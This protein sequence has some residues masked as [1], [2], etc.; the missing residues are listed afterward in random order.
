MVPVSG[1]G[2][3]LPLETAGYL[4]GLIVSPPLCTEAQPTA[5][6]ASVGAGLFWGS[7]HSASSTM[8]LLP[9]QVGNAPAIVCIFLSPS[10]TVWDSDVTPLPSST[11]PHQTPTPGC[12]FSG[13]RGPRS[14]YLVLSVISLVNSPVSLLDWLESAMA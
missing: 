14:T 6:V 12:F 5:H 10:P 11:S 13:I 2:H 8:H 4:A 9:A 7:C 1:P 3:D